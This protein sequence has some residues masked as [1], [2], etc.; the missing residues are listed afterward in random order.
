MR[1]ALA[2]TDELKKTEPLNENAQRGWMS[3]DDIVA[4]RSELADK[5]DELM[6]KKQG[7]DLTE[8]E[9]STVQQHLVLCLYTYIPPM[10]NDYGKVQITS[11]RR[12]KR[13]RDDG[14]QLNWYY[15]DAEVPE[16]DELILN[17]YK[18]SKH[19]GSKRIKVPLKLANVVAESLQLAPRLWLLSGTGTPAEA[20]G[21]PGTLRLIKKALNNQYIGP[22]L[23]RHIAKTEWSVR[24]IGNAD[25]LA[26][27]M[28]HSTGMAESVYNQNPSTAQ[29]NSM[30]IVICN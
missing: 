28:C 29:D 18:T 22:S 26:K 11:T 15:V 25:Q 8:E 24:G 6:E 23:I 17:D 13:K 14:E 9:Y 16:G 7:L 3:W 5:V 20:L 1:A 12:N 2:D 21:K 30:G 19:Y 10:R 27:G 4:R